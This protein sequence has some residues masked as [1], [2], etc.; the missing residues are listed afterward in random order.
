VHDRGMETMLVADFLGPGLSPASYEVTVQL[1]HS[2]TV[3]MSN[4]N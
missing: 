1:F 4:I 2:K 3:T